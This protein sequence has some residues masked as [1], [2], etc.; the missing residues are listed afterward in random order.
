MKIHKVEEVVEVTAGWWKKPVTVKENIGNSEEPLFF[1]G[2][3]EEEKDTDEG[4]AAPNGGN[5][6]VEGVA[7]GPPAV[8][9]GVPPKGGEGSQEQ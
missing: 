7:E 6:G 8:G 3:E 1:Q 2:L 5:T 9:G 4:V